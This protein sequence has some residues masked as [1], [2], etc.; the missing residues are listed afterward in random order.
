MGIPCP[1]LTRHVDVLQMKRFS[2]IALWLISIAALILGGLAYQRTGSDRSGA[3]SL[4]WSVL[5]A[6]AHSLQERNAVALELASPQFSDGSGDALS[7]YLGKVRTDNV[8]AHADM[9]SRLDELARLNIQIATLAEVYAP[10]AKTPEFKTQADKFRDYA[11]AW[12]DRQ[13]LIMQVFMVG[14]NLPPPSA[15]YPGG[16]EA[17]VKAEAGAVSD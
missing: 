1:S 5:A 9:K 12:N 13:N 10:M 7:A 3:T 17:A 4:N 15:T 2:D 16:L 11:S 6:L 14:G 8:A